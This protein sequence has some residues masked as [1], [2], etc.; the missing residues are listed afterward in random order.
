VAASSEPEHPE[1]NPEGEVEAG[2]RLLPKGLAVYDVASGTYLGAFQFDEPAGT[3]LA[4]GT[5]HVFSL[6]RQPKLIDL[7]TGRVLHVWTELHSCFQGGPIIWGLDE[8]AK[9]PPM[10]L[11]PTGSRFAIA[12][13]N[14]VTVIE[15]DRSAL[16]SQ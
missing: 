12:S 2:P 6:F 5:Q 4:V 14:T 11:D 9:P 3:I 10:A 1:E 8:N 16:S 13:R 7:S 15:F